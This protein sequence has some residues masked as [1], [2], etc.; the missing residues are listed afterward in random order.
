MVSPRC[1]FPSVPNLVAVGQLPW[2][3]EP[4][5]SLLRFFLGHFRFCDIRSGT[6]IV[7]PWCQYRFVQS[8]VAI[9]KFPWLGEQSKC[10]FMFLEVT[11]GSLM[12]LP[13]LRC[14]LCVNLHLCKD[15]GCHIWQLNAR[16]TSS[17]V[18]NFFAA[19]FLIWG[20]G[21]LTAHQAVTC[22]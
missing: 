20:V 1:Q 10:R 2:L 22:L 6:I 15:L 17:L 14:L 3:R 16:V 8:L 19:F 18:T 5:K 4:N 12:S 21:Y 11:S 13:V 7:F 9:G